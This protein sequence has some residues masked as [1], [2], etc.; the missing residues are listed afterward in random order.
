MTPLTSQNDAPL[1]LVTSVESTATW[2]PV[3]LARFLLV[4]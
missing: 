4:S 2:A 1:M 3:D